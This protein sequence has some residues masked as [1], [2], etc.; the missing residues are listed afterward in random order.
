MMSNTESEQIKFK[1]CVNNAKAVI[2]LLRAIE[3]SESAVIAFGEKGV[4]ISTEKYRC[5]QS[6]AFLQKELFEDYALDGECEAIKIDLRLLIDCIGVFI[7]GNLHAVAD[8]NQRYSSFLRNNQCS[9]DAGSTAFN[10]QVSLKFTYK[11]YG[12]PLEF[13][14]EENDAC[15]TCTIETYPADDMPYFEISGDDV[16]AKVILESEFLLDVFVDFDFSSPFVRITCSK[17]RKKIIFTTGSTS[18]IVHSTIEFDSPPVLSHAV[19]RNLGFH[20]NLMHLKNIIKALEKSKK[21]A[22]RLNSE[23]LLCIQCQIPIEENDKS[24]VEFYFL[25]TV[26]NQ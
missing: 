15:T 14:V 9:L 5:I 7:T 13:S 6:S 20:Y 3:I 16:A 23:G 2:Q 24:F 8:V 19:E 21:T 12:Y 26:N 4:R 11:G 1:G 25:P 10:L 18:G 22:I 17:E